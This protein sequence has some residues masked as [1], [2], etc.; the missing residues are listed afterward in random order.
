MQHQGALGLQDSQRETL[1]NAIQEAQTQ[2]LRMQWALASEGEKL[3]KLLA[4]ETLDEKEVLA[5]VDRILMT[6]REIKRAQMTLMVR[7]RNTLTPE[8]RTRLRQARGER[9]D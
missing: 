7:I 9:E 6:E 8:Q 2:T 5:Q 1:Q 3:T 4:A